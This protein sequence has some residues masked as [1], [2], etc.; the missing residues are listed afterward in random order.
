[1]R[2]AA[3]QFAEHSPERLENVRYMQK[4]VVLFMWPQ[5]KPKVSTLPVLNVHHHLHSCLFVQTMVSVS[6]D[7][8]QTIISQLSSRGLSVVAFSRG[9]PA[10]LRLSTPNPPSRGPSP[11][12]TLSMETP[13]YASGQRTP[14]DRPAQRRRTTLISLI[15]ELSSLRDEENEKERVAHLMFDEKRDGRKCWRRAWWLFLCC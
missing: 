7:A 13:G 6:F 5:D 9:S 14:V 15:D 4:H 2:H 10:N 3:I 8:E 11:A 1:M 12:G